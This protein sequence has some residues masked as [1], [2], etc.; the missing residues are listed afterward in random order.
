M[1]F[2]IFLK[3]ETILF[4]AEAKSTEKHLAV[5]AC[6]RLSYWTEVHKPTFRW[7]HKILKQDPQTTHHTMSFL[8]PFAWVRARKS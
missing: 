5:N 8:Q 4:G 1:I 7:L 3:F 6:W 2:F